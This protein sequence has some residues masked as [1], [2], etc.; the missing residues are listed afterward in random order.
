MNWGKAV[1]K[2]DEVVG[3]GSVIVGAVAGLASLV[4]LAG[5]GVM[6]ATGVHHEAPIYVYAPWL[7][8][9]F[10]ITFGSCLGYLVARIGGQEYIYDQLITHPTSPFNGLRRRWFGI[11]GS[12][13]TEDIYGEKRTAWCC[14]HRG[15]Q[16]RHMDGENA[17]VSQYGNKWECERNWH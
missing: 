14:L 9:W 11:C 7:A 16:G 5:W 17:H 6:A 8:K 12:S 1:E 2:T 4:C 13:H 15:H 3:V 10:G